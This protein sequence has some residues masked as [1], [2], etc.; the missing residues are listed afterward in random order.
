MGGDLAWFATPRA[1]ALVL[2]AATLLVFVRLGATDLWPPDEPRYA[3]VA[4][5]LR[6]MDH[7]PGGLVL[8]HLHGEPY[9]QKPPLFYWLAA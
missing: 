5:E 7:G 1:R 6:A 9:T 2:V 4:E 3:L 8:L